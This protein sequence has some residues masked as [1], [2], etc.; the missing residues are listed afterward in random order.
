VERGIA[1]GAEVRVRWGGFSDEPVALIRAKVVPLP[2]MARHREKI[3][4]LS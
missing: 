1:D 4:A 2:F 3:L